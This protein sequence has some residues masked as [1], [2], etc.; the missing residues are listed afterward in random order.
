MH[1][2]SLPVAFW[3]WPG[4][5][6]AHTLVPSSVWKRPVTQSTHDDELLVSFWK[7][8]GSHSRHSDVV[9]AG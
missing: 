1:D 9:A 4:S 7:R 3:N 2:E 8:P 5:H 6:S